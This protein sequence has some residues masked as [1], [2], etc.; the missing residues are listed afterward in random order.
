MLTSKIKKQKSRDSHIHGRIKI[1]RLGL[2]QFY[3]L[4]YQLYSLS[5]AVLIKCTVAL[6]GNIL[7]LMPS[8]KQEHGTMAVTLQQSMTSAGLLLAAKM[9][10]FLLL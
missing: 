10:L 8:T 4:Q 3:S 9:T 2:D 1:T 6:V 5:S 7:S